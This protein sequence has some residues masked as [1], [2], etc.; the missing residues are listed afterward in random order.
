MR[1]RC[2][3]EAG[4]TDSFG[5]PL[6]P[7][8][9]GLGLLAGSFCPHNDGEVDRRAAFQHAIAEGVLPPGIAADDGVAIV[10]RGAEL[11]EIVSSRPAARAWRVDRM[12][13]G[14]RETELTLAICL[15]LTPSLTCTAARW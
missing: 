2:A 1:V 6:R 15:N 9:D 12:A 8:R 13:D 14:A 3:G 5:R 7:L 11:V 10:Y 4:L